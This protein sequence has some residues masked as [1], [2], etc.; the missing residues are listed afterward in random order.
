M[1]Y[2][3]LQT[4]R[5]SEAERLALAESCCMDGAAHIAA[6]AR[7]SRHDSADVDAGAAS[8]RLYVQHAVNAANIDM[9]FAPAHSSGDADSSSSATA[10]T[11]SAAAAVIVHMFLE[12]GEA[13]LKTNTSNH[14]ST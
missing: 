14:F 11:S 8:Q 3:V 1:L 5:L 2:C 12:I 10:A 9:L 4:R 6:L 13:G 7:T